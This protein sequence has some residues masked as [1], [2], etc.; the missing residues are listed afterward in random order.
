[1]RAKIIFN[2]NPQLILLISVISCLMVTACQA[3]TD[4]EVTREWNTFLE[5]TKKSYKSPVEASRRLA[6]FKENLQ[7]IENHNALFE[8]G[9]VTYKKAVTKF[10]DL[11]K[12]EFSQ[13]IN[14]SKLSQRPKQSKNMFKANPN[15]TV[16]G[17]I[18]W[19]NY[20]AVTYVKDQGQCGSCWS[21]SATGSMEGQAALVEGRQ[22]VLSEQNLIDCALEEYGND[23]CNGGSMDGAFE[24]VTFYG[25]DSEEDYPY[26]EYQYYCRQQGSVFGIS[27]Y[28]DVEQD[29]YT[30]QLAVAQIGPISVGIDATNELQNY[31]SGILIDQTC[32]E[33]INHGVLVVGYGSEGGND[34]WIIKN[35]WGQNWGEQ[36]Y[37]RLIRGYSACGINLMASYPIV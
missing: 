24:Y 34:Y 25:I 21:F 11:T 22:L 28:A 29:E 27:S 36:G 7:D 13:Y 32:G 37:F 17:E 15:L 3:L 16:A 6:I 8:Q 14:K 18:D 20:G 1:M 19:R 31:G 2:M 5:K 10:T 26:L 12:E 23:G 9:K 33:Q 30:L 4:D 35:S